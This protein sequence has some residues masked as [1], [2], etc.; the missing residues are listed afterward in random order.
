M[1]GA[2][3]GIDSAPVH[4][5]LAGGPTYPGYTPALA[6]DLIATVR[7]NYDAF[8]DAEAEVLENHGY[9]L[10]EA[11]TRTHLA[12]ERHDAPLQIP[13]P[14]WMSEPKIREA[15]GDSS[16]QVFLGRGALRALLRTGPSVVPD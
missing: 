1:A 16:R 10:A 7:T 2:Y 4:Y 12:T 14:G 13:H 5:Q 6:R 15:L 11:A 9:L 8:S 3:W